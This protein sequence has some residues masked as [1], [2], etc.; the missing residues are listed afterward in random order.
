[1]SAEGFP[2]IH[3]DGITRIF[4][5]SDRPALDNLS[6]Q[7]STGEFVAIVGPSGSGK[8]TLMNV[9]GLLD[10]PSA[11]QYFI[12]G[13]ESVAAGEKTRNWIRAN[14]I[15][16]IFQASHV[17]SHETVL[18][19]A[20]MGLR[21]RS[22][23]MQ[24]RAQ[25]SLEAIERLGLGHRV[26][27]IARTLSGGERQRLAIARALASEPR[28]ILADE[29][30]GNLDSV[31]SAKVISHL[32]TLNSNG[33]TVVV[34]THDPQVAAAADRRIEILD[35]QIVYDSDA[36]KWRRS[37]VEPPPSLRVSRTRGVR[38]LLRIAADDAGDAVSS[39]AVRGLRSLLLVLAFAVGVG[40]LVASVALSETTSN[41]VSAS[42]KR[43]AL[44]EVRVGLADAEGQ[45]LEERDQLDLAMGRITDLRHVKGVALLGEI[46]PKNATI[47]R[48]SPKE[49]EPDLAIA[50]ATA[51]SSYFDVLEMKTTPSNAS[52]LLD[53]AKLGPVA[54]VSTKAAE[55]LGID[56]RQQ[57]G[58]PPGTSVWVNGQL[59]PIVGFFSPDD[60]TPELQ[61]SV[62][63][64]PEVVTGIDQTKLS[65]LV[66]TEEGFPAAVA[67]AIPLA[68]SPSN[69]G[70]VSVQTVADLQGL[71]MRVAN[72]I[73]AYIAILSVMLILLAAISAATAMYLTVQSRSS[74]IALRRALGAG[75][76]L[77]FRL[78]LLEG[79]LVGSVGGLVGGSLGALFTLVISVSN[80]WTPILPPTLT[81]IGFSVGAFTGI[82]SSIYPAWLASKQHPANAIRS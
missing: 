36:S 10:R 7:I 15:G 72:D 27:A 50:L 66:K 28:L 53:G 68:F 19:N 49:T 39:L 75:R 37:R 1:M 48:F 31:N 79:L 16:F 62:V 77:I 8:S 43:A 65:L 81:A 56:T 40:G 33:T 41:Q 45:L 70:S 29:P 14:M 42:L 32:R 60:R 44:D 6:L 3:L 67:K 64:S 2:A 80:G 18:S 12:F 58:P 61:A 52:L 21:T 54:M 17:L 9:L 78:F 23:R 46:S 82:L 73:G 25:A 63:V 74:E 35:G 59:V 20:A 4:D 24:D 34:I 57:S 76:G 30:T 51:S 47:T 13:Q 69:P 55:A 38:T 5:D 26:D 22:V 11:G 71:R